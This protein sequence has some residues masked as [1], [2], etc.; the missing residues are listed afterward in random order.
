MSCKSVLYADFPRNSKHKGIV[1]ENYRI[2]IARVSSFIS[3]SITN[4]EQAWNVEAG[5]NLQANTVIFEIITF[6]IRKHFKTVTV[7]VILGKLIQITF[8]TV[9]GN[10]W[11]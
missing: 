10:Q 5:M 11:K 1:S 7:T 8:K 2:Q 4:P 9:I 6:L 3:R